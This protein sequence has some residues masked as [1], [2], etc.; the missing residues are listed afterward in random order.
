MSIGGFSVRIK[1]DSFDTE[2][3]SKDLQTVGLTLAVNHRIF[4]NKSNA[5]E[6]FVFCR[7]LKVF[8]WFCRAIIFSFPCKKAAVMLNYICRIKVAFYRQAGDNLHI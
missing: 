6:K 1:K 8:A 4:I 3:F 5:V 2:A 7:I